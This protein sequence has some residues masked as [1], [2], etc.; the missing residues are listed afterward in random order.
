M[1]INVGADT[2]GIDATPIGL[3]AD[4]LGLG[5]SGESITGAE[6]LGAM[7]TSA[8]DLTSSVPDV[9]DVVDGGIPTGNYPIFDG[10]WEMNADFFKSNTVYF[11]FDRSNVKSGE[12][13]KVEEV[14]LYLQRESR[15]G[16]L[17]DGHCDERGTEEYNRAL[18]E[19][20]ALS[21]RRECAHRAGARI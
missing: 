3:T 17:I 11:D 6:T 20:R 10:D 15:N 18:G 12:R 2:A 19:R 16:I 9:T 14:G 8:A 5:A 13:V 1:P 4:P 7:D 21:V